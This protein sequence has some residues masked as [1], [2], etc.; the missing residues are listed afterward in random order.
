[1]A[2]W[3]AP[4]VTIVNAPIA[5]SAT[6]RM[7]NTAVVKPAVPLPTRLSQHTHLDS[8]SQARTRL[9]QVNGAIL[10]SLTSL[11]EP[12]QF[13]PPTW[14]SA[15]IFGSAADATGRGRRCGRIIGNVRDV[16]I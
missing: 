11:V 7:A 2:T 8:M 1:M 5:L 9:T 3:S 14:H 4:F 12:L 10:V 15:P 6:P 13:R 16:D